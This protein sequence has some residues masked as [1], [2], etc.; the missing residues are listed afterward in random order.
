MS[1]DDDDFTNPR[2]NLVKRFANA[3][4]NQVRTEGVDK[5]GTSSFRTS[6]WRSPDGSAS[7]RYR[8]KDDMPQVVAEYQ[9][10]LDTEKP[11]TPTRE[12]CALV[13]TLTPSVVASDGVQMYASTPRTPAKVKYVSGVWQRKWKPKVLSASPYAVLTWRSRIG[14][15]DPEQFFDVL[16]FEGG[17]V[18]V[19]ERTFYDVSG[20]GESSIPVIILPPATIANA[21]ATGIVVYPSN[22][23]LYFIGASNG[24]QWNPLSQSVTVTWDTTSV[25]STLPFSALTVFGENA[26]MKADAGIAISDQLGAGATYTNQWLTRFSWWVNHQLTHSGM[27][28]TTSGKSSFGISMRL[29]MWEGQ[30]TGSVEDNEWKDPPSMPGDVVIASAF[31][32]FDTGI[33]KPDP[34][35]FYTWTYNRDASQEDDMYGYVSPVNE[36]GYSLSNTLTWVNSKARTGTSTLGYLAGQEVV[37]EFSASTS[38]NF[39]YTISAGKAY[40]R[41]A[42]SAITTNGFF[43]PNLPKLYGAFGNDFWSVDEPVVEILSGESRSY[44]N[45]ALASSMYIVQPYGIPLVEVSATR[46]F[47]WVHRVWSEKSYE[48]TKIVEYL[49]VLKGTGPASDPIGSSKTSLAAASFQG[50]AYFYKAVNTV[51][52]YNLTV[53][54]HET[55][56][57]PPDTGSLNAK[58]R[59]YI[60]FDPENNVHIYVEM[61]IVASGTGSDGSGTTTIHLCVETDNIT[62]RLK[63]CERSGSGL[64]MATEAA[65]EFVLNGARHPEYMHPHGSPAAFSPVMHQGLFKYVAY[66]T[67]AEELAGVPPRFLLSLPLYIKRFSY[68]GDSGSL[69]PPS[70]CYPIIAYNASELA[71]LGGDGGILQNVTER[72][73]YHVHIT[74]TGEHD[75]VADVL[76]VGVTNDGKDRHFAEV[77]RV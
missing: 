28:L 26:A 50:E 6:K 71:F 38:T 30:S 32:Q 34:A 54:P 60:F 42:G 46:G 18:Y 25:T 69:P 33:N 27:V 62:Q 74:Q 17:K 63:L 11:I 5:I 70:E 31:R 64:N 20:V 75:W 49:S 66:T 58:C 55:D 40:G 35:D 41:Y 76:P 77:Y 37:L 39:S 57:S 14:R 12:F 72:T 52:E 3:P 16:S 29:P 9:T 23:M 47:E 13:K 61:S 21:V 73:V 65:T 53:T 8:T 56:S 15:S 10:P 43:E 19:N 45:T 36:P 7:Y 24:Y 22:P 67:R 59:D 68:A 1:W 4:R 51:N 48:P 2:P 44:R